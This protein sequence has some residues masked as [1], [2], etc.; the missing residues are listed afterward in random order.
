MRGNLLSTAQAPGIRRLTATPRAVRY[1]AVAE[2]TSFLILFIAMGFKYAGPHNAIGVMVMGW[3]HGLLFLA[4]LAVIVSAYASLG[5]SRK[6]TALSLVA[7]VIPFAP[8]FV[9]HPDGSER[10]DR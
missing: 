6:R 9:R 8:Y 3:I 1:I 2:A 7:S 10:H 5:W 4:Y